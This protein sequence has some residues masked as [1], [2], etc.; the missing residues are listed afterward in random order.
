MNVRLTIAVISALA[1]V[2]WALAVIPDW[3]T[4]PALAAS[5]SSGGSRTEP[6]PRQQIEV[7][8]SPTPQP[9]DPVIT[10]EPAEA[11]PRGFWGSLFHKR[12]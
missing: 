6:A 4:V 1:P 9:E 8:E 7:Q 5:I 11:K 12:K 3:P 10:I 2:L